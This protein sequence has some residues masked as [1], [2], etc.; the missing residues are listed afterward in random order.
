MTEPLILVA[1]DGCPPG[2]LPPDDPF[3]IAAG[4]K[5]AAYEAARRQHRALYPHKE[6]ADFKSE[7]E[8]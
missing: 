4:A 5:R 2:P 7:E 6:L 3:V 8:S 1:D